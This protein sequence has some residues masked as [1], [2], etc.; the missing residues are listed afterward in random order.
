[1]SS[2]SRPLFP[3]VVLTLVLAGAA[4]TLA[5]VEGNISVAFAW[6]GLAG[7][8]IV[9]FVRPGV[10]AAVVMALAISAAYTAL[11]AYRS[12]QAGGFSLLHNLPAMLPAVVAFVAVAATAH[13]CARM[14]RNLSNE[15]RYRDRVIGEL[16]RRDPQTGVLK[17]PYAE[18]LLAN[19]VD[20]ARR[21]QHPLTLVIVG[22][23]NWAQV[24]QERGQEEALR[25][26]GRLGE[27]LSLSLRSI[28]SVGRHAEAHFLLLLPETSLAGAQVVAKRVIHQAEH[29]LGLT[30][31]AG[32]A[33][34]PHDASDAGALLREADAALVLAF[35]VGISV[36]SRALLAR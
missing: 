27:I 8:A 17:R 22:V 16:T 5:T 6:M 9:A 19:E 20:R 10:G 4:A 31:R 29:E 34:F 26:L 30:L 18:R 28:D 21:Y 12:L 35:T 1:M 14:V 25:L 33:T 32:I 36:A 23:D 7:V 11:L 3:L 13:L 2:I 15:V 24:V